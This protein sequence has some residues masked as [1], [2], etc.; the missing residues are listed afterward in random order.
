MGTAIEHARDLNPTPADLAG[1]TS[2][3]YDRNISCYSYLLD[4]NIYYAVIQDS[5]FGQGT[6]H[7]LAAILGFVILQTFRL[8]VLTIM[9][10]MAAE[11][12]RDLY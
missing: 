5:Y 2:F 3:L 11:I 9:V 7:S 8:Y 12:L 4:I 6:K 1:V 10:E